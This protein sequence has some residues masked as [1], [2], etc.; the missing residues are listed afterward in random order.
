MRAIRRRG[1]LATG[2]LA[3]GL[4]LIGGAVPAFSST[5]APL[6]RL[7]PAAIGSL[8]RNPA[9]Y[10]QEKATAN[11]RYVKW[12]AHRGISVKTSTPGRFTSVSAA[13]DQPGLSAA[14]PSNASTPP[15]TTGAIGRSDYVEMVNSEI[16]VYS[17]SDLTAA[18]TTLDQATFFG[19]PTASTCDGQIQWDEEGH[20]WIYAGLN[21]GADPGSE[22]LY[23]G[24]SKGTSPLP[25]DSSNWCQYQIPTG[26]NL[27]DYPKLGHDDTQIIVGTNEFPSDGNDNYDGSNIY[28]LPKP[29]AGTITTCPSNTAEKTSNPVTLSV[30][31]VFTPVP[32][33]I[34]DSSTD[35]YVVGVENTLDDSSTQLEEYTITPTTTSGTM[36]PTTVVTVPSYSVPA[37]VPEPGTSDTL[38]SLD[39]RLTQAVAVKVNRTGSEEIWTQHTVDGGGPS[40]VRWYELTPGESSP[41]QVGTVTGPN[42]TFAFMGAISPS[43]DGQNAAIFYNSGS[44]SQ[45]VDL[46]V[47]DQ[48][49]GTPANTMSEDAQLGTSGYSD[50]D[51][52][53]DGALVS[54]RWGDYNGASPDPSSSCLVWGTAE[55]TTI[56]PDA[57]DG[58]SDA[59]WGSQN[60]AVDTCTTS[61]TLSVGT[62]GNGSGSVSSNPNGIG[63]APWCTNAFA[64]GESVG[65]TATPGIGSAFSGWSGACSGITCNVTMNADQSVTAIFTLVAEPLTVSKSGAGSGIVTGSGIDCGSSC[66]GSYDYGTRVTLTAAH[67]TGATF[68]GWSGACTGIGGC[69]VSMTA[70]RSVTATFALAPETLTV[71]KSGT[72]TGTVAST[73]SGISCGLTCSHSFDYGTSV[74]LTATPGTHVIFN[75]WSGA[76]SGTGNCTVSMTSATSADAAFTQILCVVPKVKGKTLSAA[77]GAIKSRNCTVGRVTHKFSTKVKKGRVVSQSPSSG[78]Q[79]P[80]GS[81]VSLVVSKGK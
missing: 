40:V 62:A 60:A 16:G 53:C 51:F 67:G 42:N 17:T 58:F 37:S 54:C 9:A 65:L 32:A 21:C 30:P 63:C 12:A 27:E 48:R 28:V 47:E 6:R 7:D 1:I 24:F 81:T 57:P 59:Q 71:T 20:R 55:L 8:P 69:A 66:S 19:D 5:Q 77:R 2:V 39:G 49:S 43:S 74:T 14:D 61:H 29:A 26:S 76:C 3:A 79:K 4:L 70:A 41:T 38:D 50:I 22:N 75:G 44:R 64:S 35:G 36:S 18:P 78:S 11:A 23:F 33:N 25:L 10:A 73:T 46:R 52:S 56:A 72:G 45:R 31:D 68:A 80:F 13:L 15:D 34:V